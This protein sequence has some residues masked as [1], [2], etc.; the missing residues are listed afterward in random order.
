MTHFS[1]CV[2][3]VFEKIKVVYSGG[4]KATTVNNHG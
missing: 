1:T 2:A 4:R 3:A